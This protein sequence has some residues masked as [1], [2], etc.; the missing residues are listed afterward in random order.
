VVLSPRLAIVPDFLEEGWP[1]MDLV[2]EMLLRGVP[3]A[4]RMG[5]PFR[6]RLTRLPWLG[7]KRVAFNADRLLNRHLDLPRYLRRRAADFDLFHVVDHTYAHAVHALPA[8]RTGVFCHDLDAF[9]CLLE[10]DREP[11]PAWF[12]ALAR[13]TLTGLQKAAIVFH[14]T[15]AVREQ[16][17]RRGLVDPARFVHAPY[18]VSPE[19]TAAGPAEGG[20]PYLLHVGTCIPRKRIDVLLD[21][22]ASARARRPDLRLV[23]VGGEWSPEQ[24]GRIERP[25]LGGAIEHRVNLDRGEIARYYRG[26]AL[27]LLPSEA[28]GFGLPVTEALACGAAVVASDLPTLR[29][30]GGDAVVYRPVGDVAA[31][32]ETVIDLLDHPGRAPSREARLQRAASFTW[33]AHAATITAAYR[34]LAG[35]A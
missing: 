33:A 5:P 21:V 25:G 7:R 24:R 12:R 19:F 23:K 35:E 22:L 17:E 16:V 14:S 10:P 9:R 26:A 13:R 2:L 1:S 3:S 31:W 32:A 29:E 4:V 28:E 34:R 11:R 8:D 6:R 27:V 15:S 18:G 30:V 20:P